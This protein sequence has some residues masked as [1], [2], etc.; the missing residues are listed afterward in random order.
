M[1]IER[2]SKVNL[3]D[4]TE[5]DGHLFQSSREDARTSLIK[6]AQTMQ[7][8]NGAMKVVS[9]KLEL[10]D[11]EFQFSNKHN[12]IH[13]LEYR[14]KSPLSIGK[15]LQKYG[16]P[17]TVEAARERVLDIAGIRVICNFLDD[18]YAV[19]KMLLQQADVTLVKRKDYIEQAK[20]NGYRSLHLVVKVPIFLSGSTEEIPVEIQLRTVAMDYWA[21]LEHMLRYKNK[22]SDTQ[23]YAAMLLDCAAT[24]AD[25]EKKMLFI[26]QHI[27]E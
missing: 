2:K 8:Y 9:A 1:I 7:I 20:A 17:L 11:D 19:E 5:Q 14:I 24:L 22:D 18:V 27:E 16:L 12:P 15:K 6:L 10:L 3:P 23:Q 26:R 13:H 25:T 4:L 21:S